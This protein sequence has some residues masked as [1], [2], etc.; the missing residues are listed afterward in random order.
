MKI[1]LIINTAALDP[2]VASSNNPHRS[3]SY[4][5]R[6]RLIYDEIL[7]RANAFDEVI[8]TGVFEEGPGYTYWPVIPN[9]RDRRDALIQ[10]EAG[11][12]ISSGNILVFTHDDHAP[13]DEFISRLPEYYSDIL[14]PKR[15]HIKT[16][17]ELNN[18]GPKFSSPPYM[19]G[20]LLVMKREVWARVPWTTV[21]PERCWDLVMTKI[22]QAKGFKIEWTDKLECLDVEAEEFEE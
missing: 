15:L 14:V 11:A 12:R 2:K 16:G 3:S 19:G 1:S 10:R 8:I 4:G 18:G 20:H 22:W 13:G 5:D 6:R 17:R 9:F 7:P 21:L